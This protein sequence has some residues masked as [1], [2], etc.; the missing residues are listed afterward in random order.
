M[1]EASCGG[2]A[3]KEVRSVERSRI[4]VAREH[5]LDLSMHAVPVAPM[6]ILNVSDEASRFRGP[7]GQVKGLCGRGLAL[8]LEHPDVELLPVAV[9]LL[10]AEKLIAR[11]AGEIRRASRA[12]AAIRGVVRGRKEIIARPQ[13]VGLERGQ[14]L[15][16]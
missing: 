9:D 5:L 10:L 16:V 4:D 3:P 7:I 6:K 13:H 1:Q 8:D 14:A 2:L 15:L 11:I 12:A